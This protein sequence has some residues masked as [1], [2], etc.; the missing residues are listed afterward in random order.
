VVLPIHL[1]HLILYT[2]EII[3]NYEDFWRQAKSNPPSRTKANNN[4]LILVFLFVY[5]ITS[6]N[7]LPPNHPKPEDKE[8]CQAF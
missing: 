3:K 4:P 5:R 2:S 1:W 6:L 8:S 7:R